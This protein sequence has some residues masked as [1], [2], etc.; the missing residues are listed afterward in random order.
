MSPL[1]RTMDPLN[2]SINNVHAMN[3]SSSKKNET[4]GMAGSDD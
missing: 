3:F 4:T 1:D 2:S